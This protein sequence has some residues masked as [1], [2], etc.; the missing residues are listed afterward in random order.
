MRNA[1]P[2]TSV[3]VSNAMVISIAEGMATRQ[4]TGHSPPPH[5]ITVQ[6]CRFY[7]SQLTKYK[8][9]LIILFKRFIF[10]TEKENV[11][12]SQLNLMPTGSKRISTNF[13]VQFRLTLKSVRGQCNGQIKSLTL[14]CVLEASEENSIQKVC[15]VWT[16][17]I[18]DINSKFLVRIIQ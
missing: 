5:S 15:T 14:H 13:C 12:A 2:S 11:Y 3:S 7:F 16:K 10:V 6:Y 9:L 17:N 18:Y 8:K 4:Y 1:R